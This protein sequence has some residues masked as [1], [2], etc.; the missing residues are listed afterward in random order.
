MAKIFLS[1]TGIDKP[2]V[3]RLAR[4]LERLGIKVWYDKYEIKVGQS[5]FWKIEEGIS[6]SE[7]FAIVISKE[8]WQSDWVR[9]EF[10][11]AWQ[12]QM[13]DKKSM[14]LPILYR[15]CEIP[16]MIQGIKYVDFRKEENYYN[17]LKDLVS[18]FGI[19]EVD[20]I[21][22]SNW[23]KF[24]KS[25]VHDW[26]KYLESEYEKFVTEIC[27]VAREFNMSVWVGGTQN[28]YSLSISAWQNSQHFE[29]CIKMLAKDNYFYYS[30]DK[31]SYNPNHVNSKSFE[32][33]VGTTINEVV[34]FTHTKAEE[35]VKMNGRP[36]EKPHYHTA[37]YLNQDKQIGLIKEFVENMN[38]DKGLFT[39][40][41]L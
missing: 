37:K 21:T 23:R 35:F 20:V 38:W 10:D 14:I 3:E 13:K 7:Y 12:K 15:D 19:K 27:K 8:A 18:V 31:G 4:D 39:K 41:K 30:S 6:D 36:T 32:N 9:A 17:A 29:L 2:F 1:H 26:K 16:L 11:A 25:K 5:I 28:P 24:S 22:E 33:F 40:E 34:E